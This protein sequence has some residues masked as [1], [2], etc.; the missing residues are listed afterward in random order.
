MKISN[1]LPQFA[2][3]KALFAIVG[4]QVGTLH[5]AYKGL[6]TKVADIEVPTPVYSDRE[7]FFAR[8]GRGISLGGGSVYESKNLK[9]QEDFLKK[10][11]EAVDEAMKENDIGA[12]YLFVPPQRTKETK[13]ALSRPAQELVRQTFRG[14]FSNHPLPELV[15]MIKEKRVAKAQKAF[16]DAAPA[17]AKKILAKSR[18]ARKVVGKK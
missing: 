15:E 14:N 16:L 8:S 17:E 11:N 5:V 7:G 3:E 4:R 10:L 1:A 2:E 12:I 13:G 18:K 9:V 6:L